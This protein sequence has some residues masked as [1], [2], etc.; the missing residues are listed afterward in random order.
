MSEGS[1][2]CLRP[3]PN[4]S[5]IYLK[6][7]H[8]PLPRIPQSRHHLC[9]LPSL[10]RSRDRKKRNSVQARFTWS[11]PW[12]RLGHWTEAYSRGCPPLLASLQCSHGRRLRL[13]DH[14]AH[15]VADHQA[16]AVSRRCRSPAEEPPVLLVRLESSHPERFARADIPHPCCRGSHRA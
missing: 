8:S 2:E 10:S 5:K 6:P 13:P 7:T 16:S 14:C 1:K 4:P 12:Y 3:F 9:P 11:C 15:L